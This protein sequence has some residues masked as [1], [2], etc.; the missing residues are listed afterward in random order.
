M[1]HFGGCVVDDPEC[2]SE[3]LLRWNQEA[4]DEIL[5]HKWLE[6]EKAGRDIGIQEAAFDWLNKHYR[7]W[8]LSKKY[9]QIFSDH[10]L[11]GNN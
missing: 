1:K 3:L 10:G 8:C 7:D 6:S 4:I 11:F 2:D 9:L 5:R